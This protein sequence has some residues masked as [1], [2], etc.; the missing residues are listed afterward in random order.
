MAALLDL[1]RRDDPLADGSGLSLLNYLAEEGWIQ[2]IAKPGDARSGEVITLHITGTSDDDLAAKVQA[3]D[4]KIKQANW[5]RPPVETQS[6]W[7]R[8]KTLNETGIRQAQILTARR[9]DGIQLTSPFAYKLSIAKEYRLGLERTPFWESPYPYPSE[10]FIELPVLGGAASLTATVRGDVNARLTRLTLTPQ[11]GGA[12]F[13]NDFWVGFKSNRFGNPA[14]FI[15]VWA[16]HYLASSRGNDM[17]AEADATAYDG[18]KNV[19]TFSSIPTMAQRATTFVIDVTMN[20]ADQRGTYTAL[21]RARVSTAGTQVRCQ[22]VTGLGL[23]ATGLITEPIYRSRLVITQTQWQLYP[24]GDV[25]IPPA[26]LDSSFT[27]NN[28]GVQI[29]A[30]RL[31]GT[32]NLE[33]DCMILIPVDDG[34]VYV[35]LPIEISSLG[36]LIIIQNPDDS[37]RTVINMSNQAL[38]TP[39]ATPR[40]LSLPANDSSPR[41]IVAAQG[42]LN[43][44]DKNDTIDVAVA[45]AQRWATLR[46]A[47]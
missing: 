13:Y 15:P 37:I 45:Y 21:L 4:E 44:S 17:S 28:V 1:V 40:N 43:G 16:L 35:K 47:E 18:T 34:F 5:Y 11:S 27:L 8:A 22:M 32:G 9:S 12:T 31:A 36:S 30:E 19:C 39:S 42:D 26:H 14:N 46:G 33:L 7:L 20:P 38:L 24:V 10:S 23:T 29:R 3:L 41:I 6:V 25:V 2:A